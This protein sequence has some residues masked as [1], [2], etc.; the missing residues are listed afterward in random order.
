[1]SR[2]KVLS[3]VLSLMM[4]FSIVTPTFA[5]ELSDVEGTQYAEA[6]DR[7]VALGIMTGFNDGTFKPEQDITRAEFAAMAIRAI[8]L[9][10]TAKSSGGA[11]KFPDVAANQW[12]S[13]YINLATAKG[14]IK[15]HGDGTFKPTDKVT[16]GEAITMLV[17]VLGY[18]PAVEGTNWP[19]NYLLKG[20]EIGITGNLQ[21]NQSKPAL[22]GDVAIL[23]NNSL[24]IDLM[25]RVKYGDDL[26]FEEQKGETL[27]SEYLNVFE[28]DEVVVAETPAYSL[29]DLDNDEVVVKLSEED[30]GKE[31]TFTVNDKLAIDQFL[32]YE[33]TI[34]V[35]DLDNDGKLE[36]D[37]TVLYVGV[38]T[39]KKD[40]IEWDYIVDIQGGVG[41]DIGKDDIEVSLDEADDTFKLADNA[42]VYY[43]YERVSN[44]ERMASSEKGVGYG[45]LG[46][47]AGRVILNDDDEIVFMDQRNYDDPVVVT[48]VNVDDEKVKYFRDSENESTLRLDGETY[49]IMKNDE[50]ASL[51]DLDKDDVLYFWEAEGGEYVLAAY[52]GKITGELESIDADSNKY[53]DYSLVVD[54][55]TIYVGPNFTYSLDENDEVTL[56]GTPE[57]DVPSA[58]LTDL[59]DMVGTEVT[60]YLGK[61]QD[62]TDG[63]NYGRHIVNGVGSSE[64][65][66][67]MVTEAPWVSRTASTEYYIEFVNA[68]NEEVAYE[69]TEDDTEFNGALKELDKAADLTEVQSLLTPGTLVDVEFNSDGSVA[70]IDVLD[71]TQSGTVADTGLTQADID[72][73]YDIIEIDGK[74]YYVTEDTAIYDQKFLEATDWNS[75]E[76]ISGDF[77]VVAKVDDNELEALVVIHDGDVSLGKSDYGL[78]LKRTV[79]SDGLYVTMAIEDQAVELY[80]GDLSNKNDLKEGKLFII[81]ISGNEIDKATPVAKE[82]FNA[83]NPSEL[84]TT[85]FN[86]ASIAVTNDVYGD[87]DFVLNE[88]STDTIELYVDA[89]ADGKFTDGIDNVL[90]GKIV[91]Q[92]FAV[93]SGYDV[94]FTWDKL[95]I[96]SSGVDAKN[97]VIEVMAAGGDE[98]VDPT[99]FINVDR[100]GADSYYYDIDISH[101]AD[102]AKKILKL[103]DL[104]DGDILNV[105]NDPTTSKTIY[106]FIVVVDR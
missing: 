55:K 47:V 97:G 95:E 3:L 68:N 105:Y 90:V 80:A 100:Y 40:I 34:F 33:A 101:L 48:S 103:S 46:E 102:P 35:K 70:S 96:V 59:E 25:E 98:D 31:Y 86:N 67:L 88:V 77:D 22:R 52:N 15:G 11:T 20:A 5:A 63:W 49:V 28:Y 69:L 87:V 6:V 73:D 66:P 83:V 9:D 7:L 29:T 65:I 54:G 72:D 41:L 8:G 32:G 14:I 64:D 89:N 53:W 76:D 91:K 10:A 21:F 18:E 12:Y 61:Y 56:L 2:K 13:G 74:G 19:S 51:E 43:N 37:E 38:T 44:L 23:I 30:G 81:T 75:L 62:A 106:E 4:I 36:D 85:A 58:N 60:V 71:G 104:S 39:D 82:S 93:T 99:F 84:T 17:R 78:V 24:D 1:M 26:E 79:K 16:Y 94:T 50:M 27:L 45:Y 57:D 42:V 92:D